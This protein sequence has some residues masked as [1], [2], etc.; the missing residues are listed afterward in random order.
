MDALLEHHS[1]DLTS[2]DDLLK[3]VAPLERALESYRNRAVAAKRSP[4]H[5]VM[6]EAAVQGW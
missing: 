2:V 4:E 1:E 6:L 3:M 5:M